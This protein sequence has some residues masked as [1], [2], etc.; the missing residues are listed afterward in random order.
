MSN[1]LFL[2]DGSSY[3]YR[4]FYALPPLS[5]SRGYPTN[6]IYGFARMLSKLMKEHSP[7]H[8]AVVFDAG[9]HTFRTERYAAYKAHRPKMPPDLTAQ[10][11]YI[12]R[13]L[14]LWGIPTLEMEGFE[15]DDII[16][17]ISDAA[18]RAC[19]KV[20]IVSP[21]KDL[22]QLVGDKVW[23]F[24]PIGQRM[25][26]PKEVFEK[27]GVFPE[28]IPTYLALVGDASDNIPGVK[29]IGSKRAREIIAKCGDI[30]QIY[31]RLD[32]LPP[33]VRK[34]LAEDKEMAFLSYE[35]ARIKRDLPLEF[36]PE[37]FALSE[38]DYDGLR[39]FYVELEF[40]SLV[41]ELP[42]EVVKE[43]SSHYRMVTSVEELEEYLKDADQFSMDFET[44]SIDVLEARLVGIS[45][46]KGEGDAIYVP[47][48]HRGGENLPIH[49]V[50]EVLRKHLSSKKTKIGH[51]L[52]YEASIL[53]RMGID[54]EGPLFDTMVA[55]YLLNPLKKRHSLDEVALEQLGYRMMSYSEATSSLM[56]NMDFSH[57]APEDAVF[58]ACEDADIAYR[59]KQRLERELEEDG[60]LELFHNIEMPLI[61]V[62]AHMEL[63]GVKVDREKLESLGKQIE[64]L[65]LS[66]ER[67]IH[68]LAGGPFNINS[69]KQLSKVL[70]EKLKLKPKKRTKTGYS[71]SVEVL[72]E[73]ALEH[74]LPE[75][76]LEYRQLAKLKSTYI[77][78]LLKQIHPKTGRVHTSYLQTSTATGRLSSRNPNL[79]NIPIRSE[80]GAL[81]RDAFVAD[82]GYLL[83]VADY[84]QIELRVLAAL[85]DEPKLKDA[86]RKG[87]D[88]HALTASEVFGV[89]IDK[90][91]S[92][93]R[94]KAKVV[95]FGIIYGM[96]PYGLSKELKIPVDEAQKYIDAYFSR[97]PKVVEFIERCIK[98]ARTEG[99]VSTLFG[100]KRPVPEINS[101]RRDEREF[102]KRVAV[103]TPVQGT[104]ADIIK[105]AM[106][107]CYRFI[108]SGSTDA[109]MILQVHDELVFEVEEDRAEEFA[110]NIKEIMEKVA[111]QLDVP[112][113]VDISIGRSW[114]K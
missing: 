27:F 20:V 28:Q 76:V 65:M 98:Q 82:E 106:I 99:Y 83:V 35:L 114:S 93:M 59:L 49:E 78:G 62:L 36:N 94:R 80:L 40:S 44:T 79:Q 89:P 69:P 113:K 15:A 2:I 22:A 67:E 3:V 17:T 85:A 60:M 55:S 100:R 13:L 102:G 70:F 33:S 46:S 91:D 29:G 61:P 11:P 95:N 75:K 26:T 7:T 96:S 58:Y 41:K 53:S 16:G 54:I 8:M 31:R 34:R 68:Q 18:S 64:S 9:R 47:V 105:M 101:P 88:I 103:N 71:T 73:L 24:D 51:N 6:A 52:K 87:V 112:L 110:S 56:D 111:P 38:P 37:E 66:L 45:V 14:K 21:D 32:A 10:L 5:T 25:Y 108:K 4:A 104:A 50:L 57:L 23:L 90:V 48:G 107:E 42:S 86:F 84:S 39:K 43:N 19:W 1:R 72:E 81:I 92:N 109:H 74:P 63:R 77:D 97:Y 30:E 12:K